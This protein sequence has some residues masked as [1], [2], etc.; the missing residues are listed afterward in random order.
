MFSENYSGSTPKIVIDIPKGG[1]MG[2]RR[3]K[4]KGLWISPTA[5]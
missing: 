1:E 3:A 5:H 2:F 4:G